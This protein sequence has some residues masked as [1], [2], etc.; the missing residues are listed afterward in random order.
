[1]IENAFGYRT[2]RK[3]TCQP[4][5]TRSVTFKRLGFPVYFFWLPKKYR[6]KI[7]LIDES[8]ISRLERFIF[9]A[10]VGCLD[11][12]SFRVSKRLLRDLLHNEEFQEFAEYVLERYHVVLKKNSFL[13]LDR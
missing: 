6:S 2:R 5:Q 3:K 7:I 9:E 12:H 11:S 8:N 1:M 10:L 13:E 4:N